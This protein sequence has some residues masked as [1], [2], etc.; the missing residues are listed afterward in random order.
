VER[1]TDYGK[2]GAIIPS[3]LLQVGFFGNITIIVTA[4]LALI[5]PSAAS[6]S[7][8]GFYLVLGST[9][10]HVAS[11]MREMAAPALI[12]GGTLLILDAYLTVART[13]ALWRSVI[14]VQAIVGA[15]GGLIC[16]AFLGLVV[17]N[18]AIWIIIVALVVMVIGVFF[19]AMAGG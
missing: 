10:A 11:F 17:L 8:S 3:D 4:L 9:T 18:L 1:A 6:I 19:A 2:A 5:L 13:A 7:H 16:A 15:V 12:T 14:V